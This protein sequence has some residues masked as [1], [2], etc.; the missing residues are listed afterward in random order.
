LNRTQN[1]NYDYHVE[2]TITDHWPTRNPFEM[3]T[4]TKA[5]E[6]VTLL[7]LFADSPEN[8]LTIDEI[9]GILGWSEH[10]T[11]ER[12]LDLGGQVGNTKSREDK[13]SVRRFYIKVR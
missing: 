6:L 10:K 9:K 5:D 7:Y 1:V 8:G 3:A 11:I 4:P 12:I 13:K 2:T